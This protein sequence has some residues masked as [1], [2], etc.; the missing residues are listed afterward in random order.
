[1]AQCGAPIEVEV[2]REDSISPRAAKV[3]VFYRLLS[4]NK[5]CHEPTDV[6]TLGL[7][8]EGQF[9][10]GDKLPDK[11]TI[12]HCGLFRN[13]A[14]RRCTIEKERKKRRQFQRIVALDGET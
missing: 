4:K 7:T 1:M 14:I 10:A 5:K 6:L 13:G 11:V 9:S 8:E 2:K 12:C 3:N